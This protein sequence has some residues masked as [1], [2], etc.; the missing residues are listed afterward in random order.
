MWGAAVAAVRSD[1]LV[2]QALANPALGIAAALQGAKRLIVLGGGKAGAAMSAALE[3]ALTGFS[4]TVE[5]I[6]NVPAETVQPL[7]WIRLHAARPA[8]TNQPTGAGVAGAR[9]ILGL[10]RSAGPEDVALCLL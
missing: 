5:G 7:R 10:A 6:V 1:D 8:G 2:R 9:Q 4:G 3:S